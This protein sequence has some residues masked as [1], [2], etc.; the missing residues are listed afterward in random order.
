MLQL[1]QQV[2]LCEQLPSAAKGRWWEVF[3]GNA[4]GFREGQGQFK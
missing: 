2:P 3:E 4:E 1:W